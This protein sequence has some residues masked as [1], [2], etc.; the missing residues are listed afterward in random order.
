[1]TGDDDDQSMGVY[2]SN[3]QREDA[4]TIPWPPRGEEDTFAP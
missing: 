3:K 2:D 1:M 4:S